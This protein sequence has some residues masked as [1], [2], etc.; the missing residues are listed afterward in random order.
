MAFAA[1]AS[2][3]VAACGSDLGASNGPSGNDAT[4]PGADGGPCIGD[5]C[6]GSPSDGKKNST[7]TDIDCGG[8]NAPKCADGKAC[9]TDSH[10]VNA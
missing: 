3:L 2:V 8:T 6:T 5:T 9:L 10:F 7:E 4:P 1:A